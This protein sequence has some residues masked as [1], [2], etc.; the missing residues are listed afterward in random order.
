MVD[1]PDNAVG[2]V[3]QQYVSNHWQPLALSFMRLTPTPKRLKTC[4]FADPDPSKPTLVDKSSI[5]SIS[6]STVSDTPHQSHQGTSEKSSK[7]RMRFAE[8][9]AQYVTRSGHAVHPFKRFP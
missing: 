6:L 8:P 7:L 5:T 9:P 3:L 4:F 2:G 1:A